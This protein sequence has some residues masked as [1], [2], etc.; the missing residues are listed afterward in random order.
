MH[1]KMPKEMDMIFARQPSNLGGGGSGS[2]GPH[3]LQDL[4]DIFDYQW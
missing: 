1:I 2:L 3:D 4:Q